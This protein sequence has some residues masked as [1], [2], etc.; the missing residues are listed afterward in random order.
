MRASVSR[1]PESHCSKFYICNG[2]ARV[3]LRFETLIQRARSP[4]ASVP[5]PWYTQWTSKVLLSYWLRGERASY[6][7]RLHQEYG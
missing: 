5:G 4:L 1:L 6:V 2:N 7:E 3:D